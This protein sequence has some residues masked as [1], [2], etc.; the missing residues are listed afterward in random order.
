MRYSGLHC[1]WRGT[2]IHQICFAIK[3]D[4][5]FR[6]VSQVEVQ[7][8]ILV[9]SDFPDRNYLWSDFP[10]GNEPWSDFPDP[11][12]LWS[13]F[14]DTEGLWSDFSDGRRSDETIFRPWSR[15]KFISM[16][17][18][19]SEYDQTQ[20]RSKKLW[21]DSSALEIVWSETDFTNEQVS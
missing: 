12:Y 20:V 3:I 16:P 18:P 7:T 1:L 17:R 11:S 8:Q 4:V 6:V 2:R 10:D 5:L 15:L 14:P 13:D 9:W 19:Q 21:S